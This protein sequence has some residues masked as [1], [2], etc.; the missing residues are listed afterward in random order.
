MAASAPRIITHQK[1]NVIEMLGSGKLYAK[2][3]LITSTAVYI[4]SFV[5]ADLSETRVQHA[6]AY[7]TAIYRMIYRGFRGVQFSNLTCHEKRACW[8]C[9]AFCR[10]DYTGNKTF[11]VPFSYSVSNFILFVTV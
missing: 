5:L 3:N 11:G 2:E 10:I 1:K 8:S 4:P 9:L 6:T 7:V